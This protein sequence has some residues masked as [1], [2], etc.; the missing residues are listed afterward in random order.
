[1]EEEEEEFEGLER[2]V[3][4]ISYGRGA[5]G[6]IQR[7]GTISHVRDSI[8]SNKSA[9]GRSDVLPRQKSATSLGFPAPVSP[10][11]AAEIGHDK[12]DSMIKEG[13]IELEVVTVYKDAVEV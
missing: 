10:T 5:G 8:R 1:M 7:K 13:A 4:K 12:D 9:G 6:K 2:K 11:S 3:S